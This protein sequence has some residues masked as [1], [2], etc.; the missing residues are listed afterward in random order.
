[1]EA[2]RNHTI[3]VAKGLG[4]ILVVLGHNQMVLHDKGEVYRCIFSFHMILFLFLS[5]V[6]LVRVIALSRLLSSRA[7]S[8]LK[9]Y[10]VV[11]GAIGIAKL[12]K[13][14]ATSGT[15]ESSR[16]A[17]LIGML[18]GTGSTV[19]LT[20][21]W[22]LPHLFIALILAYVIQNATRTWRPLAVTA[23][24]SFMVAVGVVGIDL[25]WFPGPFRFAGFDLPMLPGLP[26]SIDLLPIT[27]GVIL[28]GSLLSAQVRRFRFD[29][30][31]FVLA[32]SVFILL[33]LWFDEIIDLNMRVYGSFIV[34]TLQ[35]VTGVYLSLSVAEL[36]GRVPMVRSVLGYIGS[37][38]LFILIFHVIYQ[39]F[40]YA[41]LFRQLG[42]RVT[43]GSISLLLGIAVPLG[44][45]ELTKRLKIL[46]ILLLPARRGASAVRT[47]VN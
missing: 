28:I 42:D 38:T 32:V 31:R 34:A 9:P 46:R 45:W 29:T 35:A 18:Y 13:G 19:G 30:F 10:F 37:G 2:A 26:W 41:W 39:G 6:F 14:L 15:L 25:F 4:I 36:L 17:E 24:A 5:G 43:S 22:Y 7:D 3:D 12:A 8:L 40:A 27:T 33:H 44:M 23:L 16:L 20:P 47:S 21:M 11:L 1:V